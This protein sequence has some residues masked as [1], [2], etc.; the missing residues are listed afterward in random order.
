[1]PATQAQ[2]DALAGNCIWPCDVWEITARDATVARYA[3]HSRDLV[4]NGNTYKATPNE[5]STSVI[6][7]GLEPDSSELV[8]VFDDIVTKANVEAGK[9]KRAA[10][11][12]EIIIDYR[13]TSLGTV[14]KQKGYVGKIEPMGN[15]AFKLEF[16]SIADLLR[17][18]IGD[19]TSNVARQRTLTELIGSTA[20]A[21]FTHATSVSSVTDRRT[22]KV[23]YI[24]P[25]ADYL[26]N[27][28]VDFTSG[29]NAVYPPME[30]KSATTTDGGTRTEIVTQLP[31][32][33]TITAAETLDVSRGL[34]G[35]REDCKL[36]SAEAVLNAQAEWDIPSLGF[37]LKYPE[38]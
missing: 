30:I 33:A 7:I 17:Q 18:K 24:Q 26:V 31:L 14:R 34:K 5:P 36:I 12:K 16:R 15:F 13:D 37:T 28:L 35:T 1:M 38:S 27:G 20:A 22:F 29:P 11:V 2:K 3:S 10:I 4:Y 6:Q 25:Y 19:L 21:A 9:W 32:P 23:L 8:G